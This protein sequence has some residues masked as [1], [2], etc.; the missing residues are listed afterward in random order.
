MFAVGLR[1]ARRALRTAFD[2]G[3]VL[4][5]TIVLAWALLAP[6]ALIFALGASQSGAQE[7]QHFD[8]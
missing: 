3:D 6:V 8:R 1:P 4:A 7:D 5:I 2:D